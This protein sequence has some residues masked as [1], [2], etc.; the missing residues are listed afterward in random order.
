MKTRVVYPRMWFDEKFAACSIETK[1]L[2]CYLINNEHLGLT[3]YLHITDRQILFDTGLSVKGLET[4]KKELTDLGWCFFTENWVYHSHSCA[5]IDYEGRDRVLQSKEKELQL[6][7][8]EIKEVIKGLI[9]GYKP[10]LNHK[11]KT[12]NHKLE[13]KGEIVKRGIEEITD[14]VIVQ[15]SQDYQVPE[16]FVRSKLDDIQNYT[17]STGKKYKDYIA[18]LR[19]WVKKDAIKIR[20]EESQH[21]SKRGID[22]RSIG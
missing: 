14:E 20:R 9:T 12:L 21:E 22:A 17:A 7:P 4:G 5:Y 18:T 6:I 8:D 1:L 13:T 19:N 10:V 11:S 2:F 3:P 16:S 15:V